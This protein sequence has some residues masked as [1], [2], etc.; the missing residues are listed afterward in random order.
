MTNGVTVFRSNSKRAEHFGIILIL[1]ALPIGLFL[2]GWFFRNPTETLWL[3]GFG[4]FVVGLTLFLLRKFK[5]LSLGSAPVFIFRPTGIEV[6]PNGVL[7]WT[8]F[9]DA[10]VFT[11]EGNKSIGLRLRDDLD[12]STLSAIEANFGADLDWQM[13]RMPVTMAFSGLSMPGQGLLIELQK[14][15]LKIKHLE[16]KIGLGQESEVI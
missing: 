10:L 16:R 14:H 2:Y 11:Y 15:G 3:T 1:V 4:V 5:L 9:K 12:P 13:F 7:P 6:P 8:G